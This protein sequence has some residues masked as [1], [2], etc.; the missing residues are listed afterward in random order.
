MTSK[1]Y[2]FG[3]AVGIGKEILDKYSDCTQE[4][5]IVEV[6]DYWLRNHPNQLT[7]KDVAEALKKIDLHLLAADILKV[8]ETGEYH[9]VIAHTVTTTYYRKVAH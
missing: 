4:E 1:W 2:Q 5:G 9:R 8:Y 7:W 6:M 3:L